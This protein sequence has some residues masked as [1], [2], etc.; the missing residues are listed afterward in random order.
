VH[1]GYDTLGP[2]TKKIRQSFSLTD[3]WQRLVVSEKLSGFPAPEYRISILAYS[4][5]AAVQIDALQF[6]EGEATSYAPLAP[7][8][9]GLACDKPGNIFYEDEPIR[10]QLL[11]FNASSLPV[12]GKAGYAVHDYLNRK[13]KE[14]TV[15]IHAPADSGWR[16]GLDLAVGK[17]GP[18]RVTVW[19]DGV[20]GTDEEGAFSVVPRPRREGPDPTSMMG[21][22][23][24][25]SDFQYDVLNRLGIK[26]TRIMS[27]AIYFRWHAIE[28]EQG[29]FTWY[30]AE[31]QKTVRRGLG[32][33]G[34]IGV[35]E[36]P[37]WADRD[38]KPDVALWEQ[39]VFKI[40][41]H[42]RP[43][44][45]H[46][47]V[48]NEPIH[49][50]PPDFYAEMLRAAARAIRKADPEAKI[51]GMG[52]SYS[53]TWCLDVI[54][55]LGGNPHDFMDYLSTHIYS[56][57]TDPLNP[58]QDGS[59]PPFH[60]KIMV[61]YQL[62]VW[63]T[64]TGVWCQGF[65]Q[66]ANSGFR[67][68]GEPI[69]PAREGW[70]YYRGGDYEAAVVA[71][72]FVH[73]IGNGFARYFYYDCRF[74]DRGVT[75]ASHCTIFDVGDTIRAKGI[76]YAVAGHFFD[77]AQSRGNASPNANTFAYVFDRGGTALAAVFSASKENM[78]QRTNLTLALAPGQ[79]KVYD[80]MGNE[81]PANGSAVVYGRQPVYI[82]G[83]A[84]L[85]AE[86]LRAAISQGVVQNV[87]DTTPPAVS[88]CDAPRGVISVRSAFIRWIALDD[89]ACPIQGSFGDAIEYSY[90]LLGRDPAWSPWTA[91]IYEF[92][93]DLAPGEY[94][95]EVQAKNASGNVSEVVS[96][97]FTVAESGALSPE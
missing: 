17:R 26:W 39:S 64:E 10:M 91:R 79:F 38:G 87:A 62:E 24:V 76:A 65:Y 85:S 94:R 5:P 30:D 37:R 9:V 96:R 83:V 73:S 19:V 32:I 28:P 63:N 11:A 69:F 67:S 47:E 22:H 89:T 25:A 46:W 97:E 23:A 56:E 6:E 70:R 53:Y 81:L 14:G 57:K 95:F 8:E 74:D 80:L 49:H 4:S 54:N 43:W 48:W 60:D 20:Q 33:L 68:A 2:V 51:V 34:T 59:E 44:V 58:L 90:R 21:I 12:S 13:V 78:T 77:H 27:P 84:G 92:F 75:N 31:I 1:Q 40:V 36:W 41:E 45:K 15:E 71:R 93:E 29:K 42:Y 16:G 52:G 66:G 55:S 72:N 18:F 7:L 3:R 61:P 82:E 86:A 88:I 50:F 35:N